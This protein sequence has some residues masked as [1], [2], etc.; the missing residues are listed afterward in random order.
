LDNFIKLSYVLDEKYKIVLVGVNEKQKKQ[1]PAS[2]LALSRT[3]NIKEL[4]QIYSAAD[5]F[6]NPTNEDNFPTT[7]LEALAC[8]TPVITYKTG[9]SPEAINSTCGIIVEQNDITALVDAI[10]KIEEQNIR[11]I[12]LNAP[13]NSLSAKGFLQNVACEYSFSE[14]QMQWKKT[15]LLNSDEIILRPSTKDDLEDAIQLD[16]KCFG[17]DESDARDYNTML[18]RNRNEGILII[19]KDKKTVGKIRVSHTDGEAWIYGFSV[20]PEYQ[21]KGIGRKVLTNIVLME[22]QKGNPIFL[23]VEAKNAY[24]L[25]LYES[26]GFRSYH[27][28]DY[29]KFNG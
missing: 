25:G 16:V 1:I 28:Q 24:A 14:Y 26:C 8:G 29:Y 17:F 27:S 23:E 3:N 12:L 7:N 9:G 15:E 21:G 6:I 4:A 11:G 20:F 13:A 19:E 18:N 5:V 10:K 2:I 22:N